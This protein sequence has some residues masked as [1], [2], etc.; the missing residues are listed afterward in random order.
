MAVN[1]EEAGVEINHRPCGFRPSA[2][3]I[4]RLSASDFETFHLCAIRS[5]TCVVSTSRAYVDRI[6]LMVI[7]T[8]SGHTPYFGTYKHASW[9]AALPPPAAA[10]LKALAGQF[11]QL[12]ITLLE[13]EV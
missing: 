10:T 6:V 4:I 9:L 12:R 7:P 5:S 3:R 11:Y 8:S 1:D 13:V 2:A